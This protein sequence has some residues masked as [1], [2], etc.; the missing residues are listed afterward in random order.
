MARAVD[1]T[2]GQ[3]E[4]R[5]VAT[6]TPESAASRTGG[7]GRFR[8]VL[9]SVYPRSTAP[10]RRGISTGLR[11]EHAQTLDCIFDAI[12]DFHA[13]RSGPAANCRSGVHSPAAGQVRYGDA[14]ARRAARDCPLS[15][16]VDRNR[17]RRQT[18]SRSRARHAR[19]ACER[20]FRT[21]RLGV[22]RHESRMVAGQSN[23][24]RR[25]ADH[26]GISHL[27]I[28]LRW[29]GPVVHDRDPQKRRR[30][31]RNVGPHRCDTPCG[32]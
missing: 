7:Q 3:P 9:T 12:L 2:P 31:L 23:D 28:R 20:G 24:R 32:G 13:K 18:Y 15:G 22:L 4:Q 8:L 14:G 27:P 19:R 29:S 26:D 16:R 25:R 5:K 21:I 11:T 17:A 30:H 1:G 10:S 6:E